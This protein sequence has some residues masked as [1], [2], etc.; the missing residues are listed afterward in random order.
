MTYGNQVRL[1]HAVGFDRPEETHVKPPAEA[2]LERMA[3]VQFYF[4]PDNGNLKDYGPGG[5]GLLG[6]KGGSRGRMAL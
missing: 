1:P 3:D 4:Q 5:L 6:R 2:Y